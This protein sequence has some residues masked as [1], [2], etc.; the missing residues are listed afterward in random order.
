MLPLVTDQQLNFGP[1]IL[2]LSAQWPRRFSIQLTVC[3]LRLYL[4]SFAV[5]LLQ[6]TM[7]KALLQSR[8]QHQPHS[9]STEASHCIIGSNH[10]HGQ[11]LVSPCWLFLIT[12]LFMCW[13][14]LHSLPRDGGWLTDLSVPG[15]SFLPFLTMSVTLVFFQ[16]FRSICNFRHVS[17]CTK[18]C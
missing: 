15:S 13:D 2:L 12:L 7:L 17:S 16:A 11:A 14:L 4:T 18:C 8:K 9:T 10:R 5:G 1:G 3:L 6:R